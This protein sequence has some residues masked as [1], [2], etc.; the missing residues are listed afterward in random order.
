MKKWF[1]CSKYEDHVLG[2]ERHKFGQKMQDS[3]L[4]VPEVREAVHKFA[5]I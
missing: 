1:Q 3:I 5:K 4:E 2:I